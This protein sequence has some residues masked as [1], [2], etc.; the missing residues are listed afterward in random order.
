MRELFLETNFPKDMKLRHLKDWQT[1]QATTLIATTAR[2]V[3]VNGEKVMP[4]LA[5]KW[6]IS[7][8]KKEYTFYLNQ[9]ACF[10]DGSPITAEDVLWCFKRHILLE[11][12]FASVLRECLL[13]G[14]LLKNYDDNIKGLKVINKFTF[15]VRFFEPVSTF[16]NYVSMISFTIFKREDCS[17]EEDNIT[18]P[19]FA[20]SGPYSIIS[21]NTEEVVL[22]LNEKQ[23]IKVNK[24]SPE[25]V[26]IK[27]ATS[28]SV[29]SF[30]SGK[31][32]LAFMQDIT[33]K[34]KNLD[35]NNLN[36]LSQNAVQFFLSP[37]FKGPALKYYPE[38]AAMIHK[39]LDRKLLARLVKKTKG[40][41]LSVDAS[42][43]LSLKQFKSQVVEN[44]SGKE[45]SENITNLKSMN[46]EVTIAYP[47][48]KE[49]Y[50]EALTEVLQDIGIRVKFLSMNFMDLKAMPKTGQYDFS[51]RGH[52]FHKTKPSIIIPF[53]LNSDCRYLNLHPRYPIYE[54]LK[55]PGKAKNIFQHS[56]VIRDFNIANLK[57]GAV[58][59]LYTT[60]HFIVVS[61]TVDISQVD[62]IEDFYFYSNLNIKD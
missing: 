13:E 5:E 4:Y 19:R 27:P 44:N 24:N 60:R 55:S 8:D 11:G 23:W 45:R 34:E 3:H 21:Y 33:L 36:I 16:L 29:E 9:N 7:Q 57:Y 28:S 56:V 1:F 35:I 41:E 49:I 51:L 10:S 48:Q 54:F 26:S 40:H 50:V 58:I 43:H 53:L 6:D 42:M 17:V 39:A 59:P 52:G 47:S 20:S 61:D 62:D 46:L 15:K 2:L 32:D 25:R 18:S 37:D 38:I 14:Q 30:L 12:Q 22:I 31:N